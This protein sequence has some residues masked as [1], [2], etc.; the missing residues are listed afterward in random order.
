MSRCGERRV[1]NN[2]TARPSPREAREGR[3]DQLDVLKNVA[4]RAPTDPMP[5]S[6]RA[7]SRPS[8]H[9]Q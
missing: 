8:R 4:A 3:I 5:A 9:W 1:A 7:A 2:H 6:T